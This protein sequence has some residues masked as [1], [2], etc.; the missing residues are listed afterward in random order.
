MGTSSATRNYYADLG[1]S[2][3]AD[4]DE[5]K[6]HFRRLAR[7]YHPDRNPGHEVEVVSK[8]QELQ[9]AYEV[10]CDSEKRSKY[11]AA[12]AKLQR[13]AT[14]AAG[15]PMATTAPPAHTR[16]DTHGFRRPA[17]AQTTSFD[18][19]SQQPPQPQSQAR[20]TPKSTPQ[21]S[22]ASTRQGPAP[23][24]GAETLGAFAR[25]AQRW[26][27]GAAFEEASRNEGKRGFQRMPAAG[28]PPSIPPRPRQ[29]PTAPRP[30]STPTPP[31]MP[32]GGNPGFPGLSRTASARRMYYP[33]EKHT[34]RSAYAYVKGDRP[35]PTSSSQQQYYE[36]LRPE[37]PPGGR[38]RTS[39]YHLRHSRSTEHADRLERPGFY[40]REANRYASNF[41]ERTDIHAP[42]GRSASV[43]HP[44][45]NHVHDEESG[46]FGHRPRSYHHA[47]QPDPPPA[48][49]R[50]ASPNM[51][52]ASYSSSSGGP[53]DE[54]TYPQNHEA[55][56]KQVPK[57]RRPQKPDGLDSFFP[58]SGYTHIVE[59]VP[60][61]GSYKYPPPPTRDT[62]VRQPFPNTPFSNIQRNEPRNKESTSTASTERPSGDGV[63]MPAK[64]QHEDWA[65][66]L[67]QER[68]PSPSKQ[69]R[70]TRPKEARRTTG[71]THSSVDAMDVDPAPK[72]Y[73]YPRTN[74][75]INLDD[76]KDTA[77]L[78]SEGGL[79]GMHD[80]LKS[81]LP[82]ESRAAP[83]PD[84][85]K[86][87]STQTRLK[88]SDLPR[89]PKLIHPPPDDH[90]S[91]QAWQDYITN[92]NAYV[93]DWAQYE[94][95]IIDHFHVRNRLL[96]TAMADDWV[97][98]PTDGPPGNEISQN[99]FGQL[100][101]NKKAGYGTY[102]D[103]LEDDKVC[104]VAWETACE[105]HRLCLEELGKVRERLKTT[106]RSDDQS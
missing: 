101:T 103:W 42:L 48:R 95:R 4:E 34:P 80:D 105:R 69:Q 98:S 70:G 62:P 7:E 92:I 79:N 90:S 57:S 16:D 28:P 39:A 55:R 102:M 106:A 2:P 40:S 22:Y 71:S 3:T 63:F 88:L 65:E 72:D 9:Q 6:K 60:E 36:T 82:F 86:T 15:G 81:S 94:E 75:N 83:F 58:P 59:D 20:P 74:G 8:F 61:N 43:R 56:P 93:R 73:A 17:R 14:T 104:H 78:S 50:S 26:D 41:G 10:L 84:F 30:P 54:E 45:S 46:P 38:A 19:R 35:A 77:P 47:S 12:R 76:L 5:I 33:D 1:V 18:T 66:K 37:S 99:D 44:Q 87:S 96:R 51:R 64:F 29:H 11:D 85:E 91:N 52:R 24:A 31:D 27:R 25:G 53:S 89:P 32:S 21:Q 97:T 67:R 68:N 100:N 13:A 49:H 23:S